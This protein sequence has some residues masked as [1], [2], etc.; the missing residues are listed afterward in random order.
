MS[1]KDLIISEPYPLGYIACG[2]GRRRHKRRPQ[3]KLA[4]I[5]FAAQKEAGR[6]HWFG[7]L[8]R[9]A[10]KLNSIARDLQSGGD[11]SGENARAVEDVVFGL[12][13]VHSLLTE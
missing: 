11:P 9:A 5:P 10:E 12:R 7:R 4:L 6:S 3:R 2:E 8:L 1:I 13:I